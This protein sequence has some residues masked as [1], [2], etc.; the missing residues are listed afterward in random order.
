MA[1]GVLV[2]LCFLLVAQMG[3]TGKQC[4]PP[5]DL[6]DRYLNS[7]RNYTDLG[8]AKCRLAW[9]AFLSAFSGKNPSTVTK[10]DYDRYFEVIPLIVSSNQA[11]F[12]SETLH[13]VRDGI[14]KMDPTI[15]TSFTEP[16]GVAVSCL[17]PHMCW[18]GSSRFAGVDCMNMCIHN[19]RTRFWASFSTKLALK[20]K[21]VVF[22][23]TWGELQGGAFENHGDDTCFDY[24]A[25]YEF[26]A[27]E[28]PRVTRLVVL[29]LHREGMGESCGSGSLARLEE[30][31]VA[32]F[33]G[34]SGYKCYDVIGS[35]LPVD[36]ELVRR[37]VDII[38][39]EQRCEYSAY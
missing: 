10:M 34:A 7:C 18:C 23:L 30:M 17:E 28:Y 16:S 26:P 33:N 3:L 37:I 35:K 38:H 22:W 29:D 24:F 5:C 13:L 8:D 15:C 32:K 25:Q 36:N 12:W 20:A 39:M 1:R 31:S 2:L 9:N 11:L 14:G 21:G 6:E 4:K 27:L 19:P